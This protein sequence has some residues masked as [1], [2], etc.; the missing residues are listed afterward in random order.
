M[1]LIVHDFYTYYQNG[2]HYNRVEDLILILFHLSS[3]AADTICDGYHKLNN[4]NFRYLTQINVH[5]K[6]EL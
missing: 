3:I 6:F 4:L 5:L 1:H 2:L